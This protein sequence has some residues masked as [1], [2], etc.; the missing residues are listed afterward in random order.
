MLLSVPQ[1][2]LVEKKSDEQDT[3]GLVNAIRD[4]VINAV[5][6]YFREIPTT[7]ATA[8]EVWSDTMNADSVAELWITAVGETTGAASCA[9]YSRRVV[10]KRIGTGAVTYLGAGADIIGADKEDVAGWDAGFALDAA[11]P[12][13]IIAYVQGAAATSINWRVRIHALVR[14]WE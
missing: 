2:R 4:G 8:T 5:G 11:R 7:D 12:S 1:S 3:F 10:A 9:G 6:E 13:L 14:P